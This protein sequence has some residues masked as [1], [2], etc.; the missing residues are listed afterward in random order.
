M[1]LLRPNTAVS[2]DQL[3]AALWEVEPPARFRTVLQGHETHADG[4]NAAGASGSA[5]RGTAARPAAENGRNSGSGTGKA[6]AQ[7]PG[8]AAADVRITAAK[9]DETPTAHIVLTAKNTSGHACRLYQYPLIAFGD[10]HTAKDV[11][12][13]PKSNPGTPVVLRPGDPAYANVRVALG[14]AH[15]DTKV[16]GQFHVNLFASDGPVEGSFVV[17]APACGLAVDEAAAKTGYWSG[18]RLSRSPG[19]GR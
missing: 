18:A 14:G 5:D 6:A 3:T 11:P 10:I 16:V 2:A 1:L 15:E 12:A 9:A 19:G 8:C 17:P 7:A 4:T 13:V